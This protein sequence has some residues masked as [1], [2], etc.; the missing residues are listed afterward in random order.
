VDGPVLLQAVADAH[1]RPE[2]LRARRLALVLV[3]R[4]VPRAR[5]AP[6]EGLRRARG[7]ERGGRHQP[8]E[9]T[10]PQEACGAG[11]EQPQSTC[12]APAIGLSRS[13]P[14]ASGLGAQHSRDRDPGQPGEHYFGVTTILVDVL[15]LLSTSPSTTRRAS[16]PWSVDGAPLAVWTSRSL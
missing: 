10:R 4:A 15:Y 12:R 8:G 14:C 13:C 11:S 16:M 1:P 9:E 3:T 7:E 2:E 6:A 5:G